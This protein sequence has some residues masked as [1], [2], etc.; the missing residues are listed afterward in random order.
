MPH[1]VWKKKFC[2]HCKQQLKYYW[3]YLAVDWMIKY[4]FEVAKNEIMLLS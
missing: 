3:V 1:I 4:A 2:F